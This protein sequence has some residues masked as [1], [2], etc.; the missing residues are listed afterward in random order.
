LRGLKI[1]VDAAHGAAYQIAPKVFHELG[2]NVV[3]I[4]CSRTA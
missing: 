3:E 4:G 1:V 2:A